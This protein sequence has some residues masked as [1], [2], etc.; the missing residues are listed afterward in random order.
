VLQALGASIEHISD[1]PAAIRQRRQQLWQRPA[2]PVTVAWEESG[3]L[4]LRIPE[5]RAK[6]SLECCLQLETGE[7]RKWTSALAS[8]P[9]QQRAKVEGRQYTVRQI[10]LEQLPE[11][12]HHLELEIDGCSAKTLVISAP[13][14]AFLPR[15]GATEKPWAISLPLHALRSQRSWGA[16][17]FWDLGILLEW[18]VEQGGGVVSTLPFL[19]AFLD[20]PFEPSPYMPASRLFWNEFFLDIESIGELSVSSTAQTLLSNPEFR[21]ELDALRSAALV[22]YRRG[23]TLKRR[24]LAELA[25]TL[26]SHGGER[27]A[28]FQ[29][30]VRSHPFLQDYAAFRATGERLHSAWPAWPGRQRQ[31]EL[32]EGD[33][34][35]NVRLYHLYVQWL[36]HEQLQAFAEKARASGSGLYLDLPLGVHPDSFDVWRERRSFAF[37]VSGG[38]PPDSFFTKGQNWGFRPLHPERVREQGYRYFISCVRHHLAYA[39][40]LRIDHVMGLHRLFWIPQGMKAVEGVYVRHRP[41]EF[42]AILAVESHRSQSLIVGEDL[43]TVPPSVRPAMTRHGIHRTYVAQFELKSKARNALSPP[44]AIS[45]AGMN[46]HDMPTF[47]GF[48]A[49]LDIQ[50]R[51]E[52]ELLDEVG[53]RVER[54]RREKLKEALVAFLQRAGWLKQANSDLRSILTA[55]LAFLGQSR[56]RV[57]VV[58]LEDLWGE[59]YPQNVPGT[60]AERP[61][62]RRKARYAFEEFCQADTVLDTLRAVNGARRRRKS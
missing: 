42:Y 41:E 46:T 20:E 44:S 55:A 62:W 58:N 54:E 22:D 2:E 12:Y 5:S 52:M 53:A 25:A 16:G 40:I 11:G 36:A 9:V 23:M 10:L 51:I 3:A 43:G 57:V 37:G 50:D 24:V 29:G 28:A 59:K 60:G 47:A 38:A 35:E 14:R 13:K 17:D 56:T 1:A 19:A 30:F 6:G 34:D 61:N 21:Q 48:W 31:G 32:E 45:L 39:N 26:M 15:N 18:V 4:E 8:L 33:Y 49:G 27:L 7:T